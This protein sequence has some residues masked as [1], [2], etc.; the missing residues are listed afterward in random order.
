MKNRYIYHSN[1]RLSDFEHLINF[2]CKP[3]QLIEFGV[4]SG[5]TLEEIS[6]K[7]PENIIYG[8]DINPPKHLKKIVIFK[9]DLE[10]FPLQKMSARLK[11]TDIFLFLDIL[12]HLTD[13]YKFLSQIINQSKRGSQFIITSPNFASIRM[14]NAWINSSMPSQNFGYFDKTHLRWLSPHDHFFNAIPLKKIIRSYVFSKKPFL[15]YLQKIFPNRLC[16]QFLIVLT[17]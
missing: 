15:R 9:V 16:S 10:K 5:K 8:F 1:S 17:K 2:T 12:E 13:P 3:F 4:G 14:L 11:K 7:Y 6:F